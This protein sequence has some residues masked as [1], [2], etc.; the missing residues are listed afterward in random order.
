M[1]SGRLRTLITI[2]SKVVSVSG[3]DQT[4]ESDPFWVTDTTTWGEVMPLR[5]AE[6][7]I[8]DQEATRVSHRITVRPI[9]YTSFLEER[10][11]TA[12]NRFLIGARVFEIKSVIDLM[13]RDRVLECS[14][15]EIL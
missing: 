6:S 2:Q 8:G 15:M 13:E 9:Q 4:G 14:C 11:I 1:R 3:G 5:G 7:I 12:E 10:R